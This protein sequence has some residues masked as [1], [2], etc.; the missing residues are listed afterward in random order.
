MS[1][2]L[3]RLVAKWNGENVGIR[4]G[5]SA[6]TLAAFERSHKIH[7]PADFAEYICTVDGMNPGAADNELFSFFSLDEMTFWD[8]NL[9]FAHWLI[10]S[11]IFTLSFGSNGQCSGVLRFNGAE[12]RLAD[13]FGEFIEIYFSD[14]ERLYMSKARA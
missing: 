12:R 5:V 9:T 13:T 11:C 14:P 4:E 1:A 8:N 10:E 3:D 6:E 2:W 7:L